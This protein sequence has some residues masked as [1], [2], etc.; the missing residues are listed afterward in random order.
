M[1]RVVMR[2]D[3]KG[4]YEVMLVRMVIGDMVGR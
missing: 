1:V 2:Y 3:G 4:G